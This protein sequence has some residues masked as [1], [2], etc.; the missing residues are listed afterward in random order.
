MTRGMLKAI[1]TSLTVGL[2]T[3]V[4]HWL[5]LYTSVQTIYLVVIIYLLVSAKVDSTWRNLR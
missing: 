1:F 5:H 4:A 2:A 3:L